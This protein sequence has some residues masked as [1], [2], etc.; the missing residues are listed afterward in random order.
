M[1]AEWLCRIFAAA[2]LLTL[3]IGLVVLGLGVWLYRQFVGPMDDKTK[4]WHG[5]L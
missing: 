5:R 2:L 1:L 4:W 3:G